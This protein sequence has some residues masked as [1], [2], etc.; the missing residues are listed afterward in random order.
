[1]YVK[2]KI[3]KSS[4]LSISN[5]YRIRTNPFFVFANI[6]HFFADINPILFLNMYEYGLHRNGCLLTGTI[7]P[8]YTVHIYNLNKNIYGGEKHPVDNVSLVW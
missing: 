5:C 6:D 2:K 7:H 3:K 8:Q 4:I 1:M